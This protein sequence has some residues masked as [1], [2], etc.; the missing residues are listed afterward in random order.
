MLLVLPGCVSAGVG[1]KALAPYMGAPQTNPSCRPLPFCTHTWVLSEAPVNTTWTVHR[2][3]AL[4]LVRAFT[5]RFPVKQTQAIQT[6]CA[7]A[8]NPLYFAKFAVSQGWGVQSPTPS[9]HL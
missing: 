9:Q 4:T 3:A 7:L 1:R 8:Q 2:V 6:V 5:T